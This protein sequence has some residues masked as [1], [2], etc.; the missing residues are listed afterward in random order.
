MGS[1]TKI[2]FPFSLSRVRQ[3]VSEKPMAV[4][5]GADFYNLPLDA[6]QGLFIEKTNEILN[7]IRKE[8]PKHKLV[9][10]PHPNETDEFS[11][12]DLRGFEVGEHTIAEIY[13]YENASAIDYVFSAQSGA[14]I[15][16]FSMGF[17]SVIFLD[18]LH[19]ALSEETIV[20]YRSYFDGLP[21]SFFMKSFTG[22]LYRRN[23]RSSEIE[24]RALT[25]I[26]SLIN[27]N[28]TLFVLSSD[29]STALRGAVLVRQLRR[30]FPLLTAKLIMINHR[31]WQLAKDNPT[32]A[33]SF[34]E[35]I[36]LPWSRVWYSTNWANLE[37]TF[38]AA[39]TLRKQTFEVG[40][41]LISLA[42][43]LFEENA[44]LS[45][46]SHLNKILLIENRW[47]KFIYDGGY[48]ELPSGGWEDSWGARLF[49]HFLEP[50]LGLYRTVYREYQDGKVLNL[51]RYQKDP[52]QIYDKIL[53][54]MP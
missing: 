9:Y 15:A 6:N 11:K 41:T 29:P 12:L 44:I 2:N 26:S 17:D 31:R 49:N 52:E 36:L 13:L 4:F 46:H 25:M 53:V 37:K 47:Y 5:F 19:G 30:Q 1:I 23:Q 48:R 21:E 3:S 42:H 45:Y 33:G 43:G 27:P 54:L 28:K 8:L 51:F 40:E 38:R 10:Q 22:P 35:I 39:R 7:L 24:L 16:A 32:V 18:L 14:S 34:N 50:L 20:G